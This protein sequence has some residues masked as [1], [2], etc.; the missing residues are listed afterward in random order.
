MDLYQGWFTLKD[1]VGDVEFADHFAAYM[2][3]LQDEGAITGWRLL[4]RKLGLGPDFLPEFQFYVETDGLAQLDEAFRVVSS[5]AG[6]WE[7]LHHCVNS[8]VDQVFFA[9]YRDFPD[10]HRERGAELF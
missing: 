2:T 7:P 1:G 5:R 10:P 8:R 4:R 9:L 6:E 3:R